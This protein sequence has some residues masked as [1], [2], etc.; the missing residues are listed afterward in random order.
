MVY[1]FEVQSEDQEELIQY[2]QAPAMRG[3]IW[4]FAQTLRE[5]AKHG[6]NSKPA[7]K[8]LAKLTEVFYST[9]ASEGLKLD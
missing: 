1:K 2:I 7:A 8:L 3:F 9:L 6:E 4:E 5:E